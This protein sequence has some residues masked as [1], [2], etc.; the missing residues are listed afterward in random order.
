MRKKILYIL[1]IT[2]ILMIIYSVKTFAA[3]GTVT[4]ETL[5]L[6]EGPSTES[7][8]LALINQNDKL[9]VISQDGDWYKVKYGTTTGYVSKQYITLDGELE[10][11]SDNDVIQEP[12][13]KNDNDI[14]QEPENITNNENEPQT[15]TVS[16]PT[17]DAVVKIN[18][19]TKIYI[20][21]AINSN[22]LQ[23]IQD[24]LEV[25]VI[26]KT[27]KWAFI[28][29]EEITGWVP[30]N[31]FDEGKNNSEIA[32]ENPT[33][34]EPEVPSVE[35]PQEPEEPEEPTTP[36]EPSTGTTYENS[37]TMYVT[38]SSIYVRS[39]P[40]TRG[41][42]VTSLIK[43]TDVTVL[44]EDGDWYKVK[45]NNFE[46]YI[47]KDL[48]SETKESTTSRANVD[49]DYEETTPI[50]QN[51]VQNTSQGNE[52][53]EYAKQ[54]LGCPY[55]YGASGAS[56]FDCSGFTMFVYEHFGYSLPHSATRQANYGTY[57]D[58]EDLQPGDLVF[59]LDYET[60]DGI[61][62][63]GIYIGD[64]NFIHASSGSGYCVK[65]STLLSGSYYNRYETARR[66]L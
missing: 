17:T 4:T 5:K 1:I 20:L 14:G 60:M 3:T 22:V 41:D 50:E 33:V 29:T 19:N 32:G 46:G 10:E 51:G 35:E 30:L 62:H 52:V 2:V 18:S 15:T 43:N 12:D 65:I 26:T 53:A 11:N 54:Y 39:E 13:E 61:G 28:Q 66:L 56:S 63:C 59:F 40:S 48:L 6:R 24:S 42:I 55:V 16:E 31:V 44:G 8:V 57:V 38:A 64:G 49:R 21:P 7:N 47:R 45:Y 58:K 27:N 9:E 34:Q 25:Q 37:K 23:V 36:E